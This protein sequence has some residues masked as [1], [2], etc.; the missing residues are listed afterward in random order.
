MKLFGKQVLMPF[1]VL[2]LLA[3]YAPEASAAFTASGSIT[4]LSGTGLKITWVDNSTNPKTTS[5]VSP[6]TTDTS[7][8][9][10]GCGSGTCSGTGLVTGPKWSI[11]ITVMPAGQSCYLGTTPGTVTLSANTIAANQIGNVTC[12]NTPSFTI[13]G[14]STLN[15]APT[16]GAGSVKIGV[17]VNS[18]TTNGNSGVSSWT[19]SPI[20][21]GSSWSA[22]VTTTPVGYSCSLSIASGTNI[23]ANVTN[24]NLTC[25]K[26]TYI[27]GVSNPSG[28][29]VSVTGTTQVNA[30]STASSITFN[31]TYGDTGVAVSASL[32]GYTCTVGGTA[33]PSPITADVTGVTVSCTQNSFTVSGIVAGLTG[34]NTVTVSNG[35]VQVSNL[36]NNAPFSFTV[37]PGSNYAVTTT[38]PPGQ[39]CS[40][41][42]NGTG[43]NISSNVSGVL[44]SCIV[45]T[46]S[47]TVSGLSAGSGGVS[48]LAAGKSLILVNN[49]TET[50]IL[51]ANG[52]FSF[53]TALASGSGYSVTVAVQPGGQFCS[54]TNGSGILSAN[55]TNVGVTCVNTYTVGGSVTGLTV[56]GLVLKL[57]NAT[58]KII[59]SFAG[60]GG[61]GTY[62]FSTALPS[63]TTYTV[64]VGIQPAGYSCTVTNATGIISGTVT[65]VNVSCAKTYTVGG[66]ITGLTASGL[67]LKLNGSGTKIVANGAGAYVFS[68]GLVAGATYTVTVFQ[69]PAGLT[70]SVA[71]ATGTMGNANVSNANVSCVTATYTVGGTVSGNSGPVTLTNNGGDAQTVTSTGAGPWPF[72]FGPQ[73]YGASWNV[74][75]TSVPSGQTCLVNNGS[76]TITGNVTNVSV[77]C[78]LTTYTV[79]GS[80]T[81]LS[82]SGLTLSLN[83]GAQTVAPVTGA[84]SYSFPSGLSG[85]SYSVAITGQPT[86]QT[87]SLVNAAGTIAASNVSNVNVTCT[88]A[89]AIPR[90]FLMPGTGQTGKYS[91][92]SVYGEDA[93]TARNAPSYTDNGDGTVTDNN[94]GL[95]WQQFDSGQIL[96]TNAAGYCSSQTLGGH[97]DWRMPTAKELSYILYF[98]GSKPA[99]NGSYFQVNTTPYPQTINT[100]GSVASGSTT[101]TLNAIYPPIVNGMYVTSTSAGLAA[102]TTVT[103]VSTSGSTE[104]VTLSQPTTAPMTSASFTFTTGSYSTAT[105]ISGAYW[106]S[107]DTAKV[108]LVSG[109]AT[110]TE[111]VAD[112]GGGVGNHLQDQTLDGGKNGKPTFYN[113]RCVRTAVPVYVPAV[114][115][116]DNG[117]GT[118]TDNYTGL[119]WQKQISPQTYTWQDALTYVNSV[120]ASG[121]FA[122]KTDWRLPNIHELFSIVD[123]TKYAPALDTTYFT[124]LSTLGI[125]SYSTKVP[126]NPG[127]VGTFWSSTSQQYFPT[128]QAWDIQEIYNGIT[129]YSAKTSSQWV[130]LVRGGYSTQS[131][132]TVSGTV[133]GNTG[134]VTLTNNGVNGQTVAAGGGSFTF[135]AQAY[136]TGYLV[137]STQPSGQTCTV[138]NGTGVVG[139]TVSNVVVSCT[140]NTFTVSGT[141]SGNSGP[142]SLTNNG[143]NIQTVSSTGAG[144]WSF[145]FN[146]QNAGD[147]WNVQIAST[148]TGQICMVFNASGTVSP[149]VAN[150]S[151]NVSVICEVNT[152]VTGGLIS[153]LTSSGLTLSLNG[154]VQTVSVDSPSTWY[155]FPGAL[156]TGAAY[157]IAITGQPTGQT[158]TL[159]NSAGTIVSTNI[160]NANVTCT[161]T[162]GSSSSSSAVSSTSSSGS[163][164]SSSSSTG[165]FTPYIVLGGPTTSSIVMNLYSDTQSGPVTVSY[166]TV[167]GTYTYTTAAS[168]LV[169]STPL[170]ITL[171]GLSP[172]T[173]Y[174]YKVNLL[175]GATV[176]AQSSENRFV[177]ARPKGTAFSFVI[178][179]DSHMDYLSD[180]DLFKNTLNNM[181]ADSPDF[182]IDLGD[183][184]MTEKYVIPLDAINSKSPFNPAANLPDV[185]SRYKF[186][187][188]YYS[189]VAKSAPLFLVN[190]NHDAE[191][192]WIRNSN[193]SVPPPTLASWATNLRKSYFSNG[194]SDASTFY[195]GDTVIDPNANT[196]RVAYYSWTWGDALFVVLDPYWNTLQSPSSTTSAWNMTLGQAQY[197]WLYNVLAASSASGTKYKFIFTHNLL[198]GMPENKTTGLVPDPTALGGQ[199][200]GG[201]EAAKYFEWGGL[202]PDLTN[203]FTSNGINNHSGWTSPIHQLFVN[204]GVTAVFHGH[205]HLYAK[206]VLDGIIYQEVPQPSAAATDTTTM[207][208]LA[209][210]AGYLSGTL[211][212]SSGHLRVTVTP[213]GGVKSEY[214]RSWLPAC[215]N[216]NFTQS[217]ETG[218]HKNREVADT[219]TVP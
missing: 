138:T 168:T 70:C 199:M 190:G 114:P 86:G 187:L 81:G 121:G 111:W 6:N 32:S 49:G 24:N 119:V 17:T 37:S 98:G 204:F 207:N 102:G 188:P 210:S 113:V 169:Q 14:T 216:P 161:G 177:T 178:Q 48:G 7:W 137:A 130:I 150:G 16:G 66:S 103:A 101:L 88:A 5:T 154:G 218:S 209:T 143:G 89:G 36:G 173:Q 104:T 144:P 56:S 18:V 126:A 47:Y 175:S 171:T 141:V 76:G 67:I 72:S 64:G 19:S 147:S 151:V 157:S 95:M 62:S 38:S 193:K 22:A 92:P 215:N 74:Q 110:P 9:T 166:G 107:S 75:V 1:V 26:L 30:P 34:A 91:S 181:L 55:V 120:N 51:N 202:N 132:F 131:T 2:A 3:G 57:N 136:G 112:A 60:N 205:D 82:S 106:W 149:N 10:V 183:T 122:G 146:S 203:G 85:G 191:L 59:P 94:T 93:D 133:T 194:I 192:G 179:S 213:T 176:I 61:A 196:Q 12:T 115:F 123:I 167:S 155:F 87:C 11:N 73:S 197:N 200:R 212:P 182:L 117:D 65:N 4:G 189:R 162:G 15:G 13:G 135:T 45:D 77:T 69:Q 152:Y 83:G 63:G 129:S 165:S 39:I 174:Y 163:N 78:S 159:V 128:T 42:G 28:A 186:E 46:N 35:G 41:S 29:T 198:G 127:T 214:V 52:D 172:N 50:L 211:L 71:N 139:N 206:Q 184:F 116:T 208:N 105:Y 40:V 90:V 140:T 31:D 100:T 68:T 20:L 33:I 27:I 201:I 44:V 185:I 23:Q 58:S 142:V 153:G 54:V 43:S 195:S 160:F 25:T 8:T 164:S 125:P 97:N 80:I 145:S 156:N 53:P 84:T 118:F 148:P 99:L 79:G 170:T 21:Q 108:D 158:C 124:N 96:F 180:P 219:W 109:T 134:P 217:C